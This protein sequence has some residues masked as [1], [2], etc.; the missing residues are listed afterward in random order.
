MPEDDRF[1]YFSL[2]QLWLSLAIVAVLAGGWLMAI[3]IGQ[4]QPSAIALSQPTATSTIAAPAVN[5][6]EDV[7]LA[8]QAAIVVDL[9]TGRTLY[10]ENADAQL[11]LASLTKLLSVYAASQEL[12]ASAL[13]SM[14]SSSV[15]EEGD[16]GIVEGETFRTDDLAKLAI[17]ASSN[18]AA[19]ALT[20]TAA[21]RRATTPEN[22]LDS[23]AESAGL[24]RTYARNGTGLDLDLARSGGYGSARDMAKLAGLFVQKHP[25]LARTS[26]EPMVRVRSVDGTPHA[27]PNTN[28]YA[29]Q[30]PGLL[31]SK[32]GFTDLAGGNL[33]VVYDAGIARPIAIAVLGSTRDAR[34]TDVLSLMEATQEQLAAAPAVVP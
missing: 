14:S 11:P 24:G 6:Y 7:S 22:L 8:A 9:T 25:D 12:G 5:A 2:T 33:V 34:F 20:E 21:E 10:S 32:T 31:L 15:A 27:L 4:P 17:V 3:R 29:A 30:M 16:S 23:A 13:V 18:D 19:A 28:P 26:A 1:R